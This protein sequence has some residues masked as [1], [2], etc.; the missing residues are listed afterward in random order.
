MR[1]NKYN[2]FTLAEVMILLLTL[3]ILLAA[4]SPVF[5][6]RYN[7]ITSDEV[8]S[9]VAGD[10][11]YDAYNDAVNKTFTAQSFIGLTPANKGAVATMS[12]NND[13]VKKTLYSKLVIAAS[14]DV[15]GNGFVKR[16]QNQMQFRYGNSAA[17]DLVGALFAGNQNILLGGLY[18]NIENSALENT[19]YGVNTMSA[20]TTGSGNTAVGFNSLGNMKTGFRNTAVGY[21][22]GVEL[23]DQSDNTF[24]GYKAGNKAKAS[25]N[26]MV[27]NN[28]GAE[29]TGGSNT[30]VGNNTLQ[31]VAGSLN[32]AVGNNAL[33]EL[34]AGSHNTAV[35]FNS[36]ANLTSG[37]NNTAI[38][39]HTGLE[40]TKG[41][42]KTYIGSY[43]GSQI[44]E[45]T[46]RSFAN[47]LFTD[48][49]ER[50]FIGTYPIETVSD[51]N[52]PA[53]VIEVHNSQT[54]NNNSQPIPKA[55]NESVVINGNLIVRG[56]TYL[57]SIIMRERGILDSS[58][59]RAKMPKALVLYG[60]KTALKNDD[61]K[62][63]YG[64]MAFD[65]SDRTR[66]SIANCR[67]HK[68]HAFNDVRPNCICT[69]VNSNDSGTNTSFQYSNSTGVSTSYDWFT[70]A[71]GSNCIDRYDNDQC[72]EESHCADKAASYTDQ[73]YQK[74][75][76][77]EHRD[78][79]YGYGE[80]GND[81][82]L[83][84]LIT[85][86]MGGM[87]S[88][89][90]CCPVLTS[91]IRLKNV[92]KAFTGG[93]NEIRKINI[94]NFTFKNDVNKLPQVGVIAQDLKLIFPN[95]VTKDSKGFYK[96]R[97]DE[98]LYAAINSI[99]TL[100]TKIEK[101]AS[102]IISDKNRVAVLKK[103]NAELN[104]KLDKLA[105]ELTTLEAKKRK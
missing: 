35:G 34:G 52:S 53:A 102:R 25:S 51:T 13:T 42:N 86:D 63:L 75:V 26:T 84:H 10:S 30:A 96:I 98:M 94:Y 54:V 23:T 32:V 50:V 2:A 41:S 80:K 67:G 105:N 68:R 24:V 3:S 60:S 100:N 61:K 5:T 64:F 97:W 37:S 7:N 58:G 65:G 76:K 81:Q 47:K 92:G 43:S 20:L 8:W 77:L 1:Y 6:R 57:E 56:Q 93:L 66:N 33:M 59:D 49:V 21:L 72:C 22:T 95:A 88:N 44:P 17:G 11:N 27:G 29:A 82:P 16:R 55:G 48:E 85:D 69:G 71:G 15:R 9:F 38:G 99:K 73:S 104:A 101:I 28:S 46:P 103:D 19:S 31:K 39:D 91:D 87:T 83:A 74:N 12:Q 45:T 90:S 14:N 89:E 79:G 62:T 40:N 18:K 70:K 78:E 36:L 4:F